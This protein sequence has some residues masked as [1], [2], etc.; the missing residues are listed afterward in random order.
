VVVVALETAVLRWVAGRGKNPLRQHF[1]DAFA[2]LRSVVLMEGV[3][4]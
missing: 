1:R 2:D 3:P 4:I